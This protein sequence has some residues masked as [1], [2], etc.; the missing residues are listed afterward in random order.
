M[1]V[2]RRITGPLVLAA[3]LASC[4]APR[5]TARPAAPVAQ[6]ATHRV[7]AGETWGSIARDFYGDEGR[8][9]ELARS[10][11][12][13]PAV[14]PRAGAAVRMA[15]SERDVER[16]RRRLEAARAYN[17]GLDRAAEGNYGAAVERFREARTLDPSFADASFNLAIAYGKLGEHGAAVRILRPLVAA[18]PGSAAY[19]YALGAAWFAAGDLEAAGTVF[20]DLL[21]RE[22][23]HRGAL[24]SLA[25]VCERAGRREEA[26]RRYEAFLASGPGDEWAAAARERIEALRRP[27]GVA[28]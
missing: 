1:N 20:A 9:A 2:P 17:E 10:N 5:E 15:L 28:P 19:R 26:L 27:A 25:A 21:A 22:P 6:I 7:G 18:S 11:G 12:M 23:G 3:A 8:G 24:F 14:P 16:M 13:D 4:G